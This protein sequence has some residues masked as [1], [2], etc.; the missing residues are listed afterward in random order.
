MVNAFT[1]RSLPF[2]WGKSK[3]LFVMTCITIYFWAH[4]KFM[5]FDIYQYACQNMTS[6]LELGLYVMFIASLDLQEIPLLKKMLTLS[7]KAF[8]QVITNTT[9]GS[10]LIKLRHDVLQLMTVLYH[11]YLSIRLINENG[12]L[13]ID[14]FKDD[15]SK[16]LEV[17]LPRS[18]D[19]EDDSSWGPEDGEYNN[20]DDSSFED[21]NVS[22]GESQDESQCESLHNMVRS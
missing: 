18:T 9:E 5:H 2:R 8:F 19:N 7:V 16:Y 6:T 4:S 15:G 1:S 20:I 22:N 17:L 10:Y 21:D 14:P 13:N 11:K 3:Q 12:F